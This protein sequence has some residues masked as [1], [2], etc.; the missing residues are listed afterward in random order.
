LLDTE[1]LTLDTVRARFPWPAETRALGEPVELLWHY[2]LDVPLATLWAALIDTSRI[3]RALGLPEM[4][5]EPRA[6]RLHG[7]AVYGYLRHEWDEEP[8]DWIAQ[9]HVLSV[10]TY[11]R[12]YGHVARALYHLRPQPEGGVRLTFYFGWIPRGPVSRLFVRIGLERMRADFDRLIPRLAAELGQARPA[13]L[14]APPAP[15]S[16]EAERR[17]AS[18]RADLVARGLPV[19]VPVAVIDEL[20]DFLRRGDDAD[21]VRIQV[22]ALATARGVDERDLLRV[23]LHATRLGVLTMSWDVVC[24]H[25]RGMIEEA[26][27]LGDVPRLGACEVC[28]IDFAT[29]KLNAVEITFRVH[30]SIRDVPRRSFCSAE[31][32]TKAHIEVQQRLAPGGRTTLA[33]QLAP[34]RYRMRLHGSKSYRFLEVHG[35]RVAGQPRPYQDHDGRGH[36]DGRSRFY[37]WCAGESG[38]GAT[39][40]QPL[41]ELVNDTERAQI[42]IVERVDWSDVAL[43]PAQMFTLQEFRDL[44]SEQYLA[45]DVQL[46]VGEQAILFSDIVGSTRFYARCGDPD[47]FMAVKKHFEV[48]FEIIGKHRGAVVKTIGDAAMGAFERPLD[49]LRAAREIHSHFSPG[50]RETPIRLRIALNA[51]PCIAVRLNSN[52]DYFGSTVNLAAK[53][54]ACAGPGEIAMSPTVIDAPGVLDYLRG[55]DAQVKQVSFRIEAL[56][57]NLAVLVWRTFPAQAADAA[58]EIELMA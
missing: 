35:E 13:L 36:D 32:A 50:Q 1:V 41:L 21:L 48:I 19:A 47:A 52:I 34:G 8:W 25:C 38:D 30:P 51:G 16:D 22:R 14:S 45:A 9:R 4:R 29:D 2:Q 24:P 37:R 27:T 6:G 44:F 15:L 31:T 26:R 20:F 10:R 54:Q 12:G 5:F 33:T 53:L 11:S 39:R 46:A 42:F 7:S 55:E 56:D 23:C 18:A 28:E 49:A 58:P 3:N 40:G 57:K 17:L 43:R